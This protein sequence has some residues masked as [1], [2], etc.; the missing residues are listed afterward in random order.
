VK[1]RSEAKPNALYRSSSLPLRHRPNISALVT[2]VPF[3]VGAADGTPLA[4][5]RVAID[6]VC[7]RLGNAY[8]GGGNFRCD[9]LARMVSRGKRLRLLNL[10]DVRDR[11]HHRTLKHT[12]MLADDCIVQL[13]LIGGAAEGD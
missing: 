6:A 4:L 7:R 10:T 9:S 13:D 5:S 11:S 12:K 2:Q 1:T 3:E 8:P